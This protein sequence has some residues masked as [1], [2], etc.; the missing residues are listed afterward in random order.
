MEIV[1]NLLLTLNEIKTG[2]TRRR[3][4][5]LQPEGQEEANLVVLVGIISFFFHIGPLAVCKPQTNI[6]KGFAT[7]LRTL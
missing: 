2:D 6:I 5:C 1:L 7:L 4:F 3:V